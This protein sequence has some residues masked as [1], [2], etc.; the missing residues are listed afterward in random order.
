SGPAGLA[1]AQQLARA[2][3]AVTVFEKTD[4]IAG[5]LRHGIPDLKPE[6][7]LI[8]RRIAQMEAQGV[9]SPP[10]T[11]VGNADDPAAD[12]LTTRTPQSLLEEFDAVV[13]SGGA[14]TPRDLPVPGRELQGVHFAMEFL[15]QQNK[16]VAGDRLSGQISAKDKHV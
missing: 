7:S 4:R 12:G 5:L 2:G 13:M 15:R 8:D 9:E 11:Y 6:K 1:C 10:S 14:E 3:H 16:A